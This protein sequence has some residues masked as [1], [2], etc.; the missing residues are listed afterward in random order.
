MRPS[1]YPLTVAILAAIS[2]CDAF[3]FGETRLGKLAQNMHE[4]MDM[5]GD[6]RVTWGDVNAGWERAAEK[7]LIPKNYKSLVA[8]SNLENKDQELSSTTIR[9]SFVDFKSNVNSKAL[10]AVEKQ[11]PGKFN[12]TF[13]HRFVHKLKTELRSSIKCEKPRWWNKRL[14]GADHQAVQKR[15]LSITYSV[16]L[17]T[18]NSIILLFLFATLPSLFSIILIPFVL[19][20]WAVSLSSMVQSIH[21]ARKKN[22]AE[23]PLLP[24]QPSSETVAVSSAPLALPVQQQLAAHQPVTQ[25]QPAVNGTAVSPAVHQPATLVG[26]Q[27]SANTE[28]A[29]AESQKQPEEAEE[30]DED[31]V[32]ESEASTAGSNVTPVQPQQQQAPQVQQSQPQQQAQPHEK[33]VQPPAQQVPQ[34]QPM[35]QQ[36]PQKPSPPTIQDFTAQ[37]QAPA[38]PRAPFSFGW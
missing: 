19:F 16:V 11:D 12:A 35:H 4:K 23:T 7:G 10:K 34:V 22:T 36:Q 30:M 9:D 29:S 38:A 17:F 25:H 31:E 32:E 28:K 26:S 24:Q 27:A 6:K 14:C 37:Y 20:F 5:N 2:S 1:F 3:E 13:F 15:D 8:G 21:A 33:Q 18:F